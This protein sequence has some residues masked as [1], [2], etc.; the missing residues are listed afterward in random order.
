MGGSEMQFDWILAGF[1]PH[2]M[3]SLLLPYLSNADAFISTSDP[4]S[5]VDYFSFVIKLFN[6]GE[7]L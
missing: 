5:D 4:T 6:S 7:M 2:G 3:P 1:F